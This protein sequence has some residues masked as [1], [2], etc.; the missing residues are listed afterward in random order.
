MGK[1]GLEGTKKLKAKGAFVIVQDEKTSVV[2]G[3]PRVV[4]EAGLADMML[5]VGEIPKAI[6]E[7]ISM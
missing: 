3:M 2:W 7:K 1:D 6:V 4:Y 5:P